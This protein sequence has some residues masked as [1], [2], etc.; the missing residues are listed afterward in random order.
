MCKS[1][2]VMSGR[3]LGPLLW[4]VRLSLRILLYQVFYNFLAT[5]SILQLIWRKRLSIS[6]LLA[7][8]ESKSRLRNGT[9]I[10]QLVQDGDGSSE[11]YIRVVQDQDAIKRRL[12]PGFHEG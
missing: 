5:E 11:G 7:Q 8:V 9:L 4:W 12:K 2:G 6:D 10:L 3:A 1:Q